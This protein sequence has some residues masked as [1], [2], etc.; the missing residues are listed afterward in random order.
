M[1]N[2]MILNNKFSKKNKLLYKMKCLNT[3]N[4]E[5]ISDTSDY[6]FKVEKNYNNSKNTLKNK[7]NK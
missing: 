6:D 5:F 3:R 4:Q 1:V 2:E 7:T